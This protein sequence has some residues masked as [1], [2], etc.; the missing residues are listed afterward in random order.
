MEPLHLSSPII[1]PAKII[2]I[3][4]IA[5]TFAMFLCNCAYS[6]APVF[7]GYIPENCMDKAIKLAVFTKKHEP[8]ADI[9]IFTGLH[10]TGNRHAEAMQRFNSKWWPIDK[11]NTIHIVDRKL[12]IREAI[13]K[14]MR[15]LF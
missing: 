7:T 14:R 10:K 2:V 13:Q 4:I 3:F 12:T 1:C 8:N 9:L 15:D 11:N 5:I 6:P